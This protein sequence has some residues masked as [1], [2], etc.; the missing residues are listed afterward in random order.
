MRLHK[1]IKMTIGITIVAIS[2]FLASCQIVSF[3]S[4]EKED[5]KNRIIS[6]AK[7]NHIPTL[8]VFI[9]S[10]KV[11]VDFQYKDADKTIEPMINY[12]IGSTTK[13]LA[14]LLI[15]KQVEENKIGLNDLILNYIDSADFPNIR[16]FNSITI[17]HLLSHTSGIPDYT[18]N[19]SWMT[20][21]MAGNAPKS[22]SEKITLISIPDSSYHFEQFAY[23][24]SN[25][26][27]LE[28]IIEKKNNKNAKQLFNDFY[29]GLNLPTISFTKPIG[30]NQAFFAMVENQTSSII[31]FEEEYGYEGGAYASVKDLS[32]ILQK[33][34]VDKNVLTQKSLDLISTWTDMDRYKIN[35]G[36]A[37]TTSYGLGLMKFEFNGRTFI[38]H[39]GSS[40][41]YQSVAFIEPATG[42]EIVL[43]TNCS[44]KYYNHAFLIDIIGEIVK[45]L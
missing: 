42:A 27:L 41:K 15:L 4:S 26:V 16:W 9:K 10:E 11:I 28:K 33:V 44:G 7:A 21:T 43:L 30:S 39:P 12:G 8:S 23:S 35:Y 37:K 19:P 2:S 25:Y 32:L 17:K 29:T 13:F 5:L 18:N 20:A 24:N 3:L 31:A 1:G 14:A 40:L 6:I 38:G 45:E 36:F 34:F 22:Y